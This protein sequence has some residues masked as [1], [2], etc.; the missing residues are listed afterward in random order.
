MAS[1]SLGRRPDSPAGSQSGPRT[2]S[3]K[4]GPPSCCGRTCGKC[5]RCSPSRVPG[6]PHLRDGRVCALMSPPHPTPA[7]Q[8]SPL[9]GGPFAPPHSRWE[10]RMGAVAGRGCLGRMLWLGSGGGVGWGGHLEAGPGGCSSCRQGQAWDLTICGVG[11]VGLR[12]F[13][14]LYGD[15]SGSHLETHTSVGRGWFWRPLASSQKRVG[16]GT[17]PC[18]STTIPLISKGLW[19]AFSE[20]VPMLILPTPPTPGALPNLFFLGLAPP[21]PSSRKPSCSRNGHSPGQVCPTPASSATL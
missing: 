3:G 10:K 17:C 7:S 2:C 13:P 18:S 4:A 19:V 6:S 9:S 21:V 20:P 14:L 16:P 8:V 1:D 15:I 11:T 5:G 12:A